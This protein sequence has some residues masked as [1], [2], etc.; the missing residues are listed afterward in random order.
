MRRRTPTSPSNEGVAVIPVFGPDPHGA[1]MFHGILA[2]T[3]GHLGSRVPMDTRG[4]GAYHGYA[5]NPQGPMT[6][7]ANLGSG[8]TVVNP[9]TR[10]DQSQGVAGDSVQQV[11]GDRM[12]R[13]MFS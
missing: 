8:R 12:G 10:F 7:A 2:G 13:G 6:G 5:V 3:L 9:S 11:F 4:S 1:A